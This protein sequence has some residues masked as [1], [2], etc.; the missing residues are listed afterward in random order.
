M[1][2]PLLSRFNL[3][4]KETHALASYHNLTNKAQIEAIEEPNQ[5]QVK[6]KWRNY[7]NGNCRYIKEH[8]M[9][10]LLHYQL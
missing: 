8:L 5:M 1:A 4:Q 3:P 6:T 7:M 2:N 10:S 9:S